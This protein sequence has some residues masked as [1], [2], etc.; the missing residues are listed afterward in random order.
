MAKYIVEGIDRLGGALLNPR[1][2]F[3]QV[4]IATSDAVVLGSQRD[5]V[6]LYR[7]IV[8]MYMSAIKLAGSAV[9]RTPRT[10]RARGIR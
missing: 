2:I 6:D 9:D 1:L 10:A 4:L 7:P 3:A 5:D 8:E